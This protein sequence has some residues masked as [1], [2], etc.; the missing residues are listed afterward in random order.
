M[1]IVPC[2]I[3]TMSEIAHGITGSLITRAA[4]VVLKERRRL[5]V[6]VRETPLH[7]GHLTSMLALTQ[8]GGVVAPPVPAMYDRPASVDDIVN[9]TV[10]RWLDLFD[11]DTGHLRRWG[12]DIPTRPHLT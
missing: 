4:D 7:A 2:S 5:V 12:E 1:L 10:A 3:K 9:H 6:A 8:M 11:I